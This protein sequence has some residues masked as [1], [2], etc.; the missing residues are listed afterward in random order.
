MVKVVWVCKSKIRRGKKMN[1]IILSTALILSIFLLG[2][3][4][5]FNCKYT[6]ILFKSIKKEHF[7]KCVEGEQDG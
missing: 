3:I 6:Y 7:T 4:I 2:F 1:T 5:G